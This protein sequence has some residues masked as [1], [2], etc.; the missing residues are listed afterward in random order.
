[1]SSLEAEIE[2]LVLTRITIDLPSRNLNFDEWTIPD[3]ITLADPH[4]DT[5]GR[6]DM[7]IVVEWFYQLLA[8]SQIQSGNEYPIIQNTKF[9]WVV[10]GGKNTNND[11]KPSLSF[12]V[13]ALIDGDLDKELEQFWLIENMNDNVL[14]SIT[15]N[16]VINHYN[17]TVMRES[18][19][20]FIVSLPKIDNFAEQ[21]G[22]SR[23]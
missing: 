19:G 14:D 8:E 18:T 6:V 15:N 20:R 16:H 17:T 3:G 5:P 9:G 22:S 10:A 11:K 1:M 21:I 12:N 7:L 23:Q 4:Y 13:C 2:C